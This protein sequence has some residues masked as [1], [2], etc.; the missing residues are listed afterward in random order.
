VTDGVRTCPAC[1][2]AVGTDARFC[3]SCGQ[4]LE[5]ERDEGGVAYAQTPA[6]LFGVLSPL[7]AFVLACV[8]LGGALVAL[9]SGSPV[10]GILLLAFAAAVLVLFYG[11]AKHDP[12][13]PLAGRTLD[14]VGRVGDW[15]RFARGTADAWG[16]A[17]RRV[18]GLRRELR[19]LRRERR[20][21]QFSLGEAAYHRDETRVASLRA[22][23]VEIDYAISARERERTEA[24]ARAR[25]RVEDERLAVRETQLLPPDDA[26]GQADTRG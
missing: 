13:G 7:S 22:H 6:R 18:V 23:L 2:E 1:Q 9:V 15:T 11:A 20:E 24:F 17:G 19:A 26:D 12:D 3:P 4:R 10:L 5:G 14:V 8:L 21:A 25:T 16:S